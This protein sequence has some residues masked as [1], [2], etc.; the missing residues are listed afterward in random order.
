MNFFAGKIFIALKFAKK[1]RKEL[2]KMRDI[3]SEVA[4]VLKKYSTDEQVKHNN[5]I[6]EQFEKMG[7][8]EKPLTPVRDNRIIFPNV[9]PKNENIFARNRATNF[10]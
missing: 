8:V 10:F 4:S 9:N 1:L 3:G 5:R 6:M 7:I 2:V